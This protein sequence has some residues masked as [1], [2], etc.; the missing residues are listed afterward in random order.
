M[1]GMGRRRFVYPLE[2]LLTQRRWDV[3]ALAQELASARSAL[4]ACE[5]DVAQSKQRL[6]GANEGLKRMRT[7]GSAIDLVRQQLLMDYRSAEDELLAARQAAADRARALCERIAEQLAR[8]RRALQGYEDHRDGLRR[9][10][11]RAAE[12]IASKAADDS[13]LARQVATGGPA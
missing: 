2:A 3:D 12:T 5:Q 7:D 6:A 13:W 8:N 4:A 9:L 11:E 10:H 1:S